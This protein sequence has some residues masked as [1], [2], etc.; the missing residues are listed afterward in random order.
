MGIACGVFFFECH[1]FV[2]Q[3]SEDTVFWY[4]QHHDVGAKLCHCACEYVCPCLF[5]GS[6]GVSCFH[7]Q[8][9]QVR[10]SMLPWEPVLSVLLSYR[11]KAQMMEAYRI[12]TQRS[13]AGKTKKKNWS[14]QHET[15]YVLQGIIIISFDITVRTP[16]LLLK[17][18]MNCCQFRDPVI[19]THFPG[20]WRLP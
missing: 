8:L 14:L 19:S 4:S 9:F 5:T 13:P 2:K 20:V 7:F 11:R 15:P 3:M 6:W 16:W 17:S 12:Q 18:V 10:F 1:H